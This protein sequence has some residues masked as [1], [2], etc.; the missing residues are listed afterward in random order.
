MAQGRFISRHD[1]FEP[2]EV[3]GSGLAQQLSTPFNRIRVGSHIRVRRHV[4]TVIGVL[5]ESLPSPMMPVDMNDALL[6]SIPNGRGRSLWCWAVW[7]S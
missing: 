6:L 2:F 5:E 4:F 1:R 3:I 7:V